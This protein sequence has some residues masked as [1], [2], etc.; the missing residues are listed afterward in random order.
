SLKLDHPASLERVST[1]VPKLDEM[2]GGQGY[3]RGSSVLI[4]GTAGTGKTSLLA[5]AAFAA[6]RRNER[7]LYFAFEESQNQIVRN[8]RSIG[9]DLSECIDAGLLQFH[10]GRPSAAGLE[11]HLANIHQL[12]RDFEPQL[13]VIDPIDGF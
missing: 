6:C 12:V 9:L 1:G 4:T 8:M 3:L 10:A 5:H 11:M 2:L 7:C 13:V